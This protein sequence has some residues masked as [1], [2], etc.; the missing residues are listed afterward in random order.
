M[1]Q[2]SDSVSELIE[3]FANLP[4]VG[5]RTAERY[6]FHILTEEKDK[7]IKLA[8]AIQKVKEEIVHCSVCRNL[9]DKNTCRICSD[10]NRSH[11]TICVVEHPADIAALEK[12][13]KYNGLYYVLLGAL[14][15]LKGIHP[16]DLKI[17]ELIERI[18]KEN[19]KEVIIA[20]DFDAE[21]EMTAS[22]IATLLKPVGSKTTR[23]A[24]GIPIGGTLELAGEETLAKAM[25]ARTEYK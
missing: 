18:K 5:K 24:R 7:A 14:S 13:S 17:P 1:Y 9:T 3:E 2:F 15:P 6:A 23:P 10:P 4:G 20:T 16:D 8:E 19:I 21:G 25:E 22:Y 12:T 11:T